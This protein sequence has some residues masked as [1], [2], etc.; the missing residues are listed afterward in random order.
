MSNFDRVIKNGTIVTA[1]DT[2]NA[3]LAIK[4]GIIVE[5]GKDL[6][7][8]EVID[9]SGKYIIPGGIDAHTH[10]DMPFGGTF[11]SDDF[12]T[13]T[14]AAAIGGTTS[15]IDYSIQP[16]GKTLEDTV[17][18][19]KEKGSKSCLDYGLHVA[20]TNA[21]EN[22]LAEI[23]K[24][25]EEGI[26]SFKVFMVYDGMRVN[27]EALMN[28]LERSKE[29]GAL[30]GVHCENYHVISKRTKELLADGK[31]EPKYHAISRP[32]VCEGEAANRA[33]RLAELSNAPVFIVHN[34]CKES[35]SKI[36]EAREA[37][38]PVMGETCP[39]YLF[40]S[41]DNYEEPNFNG[42]K[43]VMSPPLRNKSNWDYIWQQLKDGTLQTVA[44]D[45]CPFFFEQKKLGIDNF[46]KIPNGGPG[47]ETRM[48]LM[49]SEGP[50][51]GL[52]LNK[53]VEVTSTNVAK[54]FGMYPKKGT[55]AIGSDADLVIYDPTKEVT[56]TKDILHENIDYT[57]FEGI[58]VTGYPVM[59]LS[60]GDVVAKDGNYVGAEK[61]GQFIKRGKSVVL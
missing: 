35:I 20:I 57:G 3:D 56:I 14:K 26:T 25:V 29:H 45:H 33:I 19:W 60:R 28:I 31:T 48:P 15:F 39:Q 22:A 42:A 46:A 9:A 36:K 21:D 27:D 54:I 50:K 11:S 8:A 16:S 55:I 24:M 37:G 43:Y 2:Y 1:S 52:S 12:E 7:A 34:S 10:L 49:L 4:D 32:A 5:I 53:I 30:V 59:T 51:H 61:R 18:I 44:T 13:G 58:K 17:N 23:P 38:L 47:I 40:L 6:N 41:E